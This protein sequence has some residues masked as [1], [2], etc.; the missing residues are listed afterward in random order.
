ML[1]V[2][3]STDP[4]LQLGCMLRRAKPVTSE[5]AG[6]SFCALSMLLYVQH[7]SK[8][9]RS[10]HLMGMVRCRSAGKHVD[11]DGETH[12]IEELTADRWGRTRT[13]AG[14]R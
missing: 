10:R 2:L 14:L 9:W 7:C 11:F 5:H 6:T 8:I 12:T 1:P 3:S 13:V 4:D